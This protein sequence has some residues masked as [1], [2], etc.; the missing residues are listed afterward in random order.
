MC[1]GGLCRLDSIVLSWHLN[2]LKNRP[3]MICFLDGWHKVCLNQVLSLGPVL[4]TCVSRFCDCFL[5]FSVV[6]WL[7]LD[8]V[9]NASEVFGWEDLSAK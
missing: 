7:Q 5:G 3:D 1:R 8:L 4:F 9:Y 6:T 2:A